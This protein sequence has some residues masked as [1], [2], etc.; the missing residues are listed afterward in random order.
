M[1]SAIIALLTHMYTPMPRPLSTEHPR[2][3][4]MPDAFG[5]MGSTSISAVARMLNRHPNC[6][7]SFLPQRS[8]IFRMKGMNRNMGT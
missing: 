8:V 3:R 2:K 5:P 4:R 1:A 6:E 7:A